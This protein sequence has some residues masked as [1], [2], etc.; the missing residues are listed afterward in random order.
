MMEAGCAMH[1]NTPVRGII[2]ERQGHVL[3]FEGFEIRT[4]DVLVATNGYTRDVGAFSANG[5]SRWFP[6]K[7]RLVRSIPG[8]SKS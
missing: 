5:S 2:S 3:R 7:S 1:G 6:L 4:R 8:S